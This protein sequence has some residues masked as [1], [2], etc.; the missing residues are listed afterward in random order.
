MSKSIAHSQGCQFCI[1]RIK[2]FP[3]TKE[4]MAKDLESDTGTALITLDLTLQK[5]R[6]KSCLACPGNHDLARIYIDNISLKSAK[7]WNRYIIDVKHPRDGFE[8]FIINWNHHCSYAEVKAML[9]KDDRRKG[10][11]Q[12]EY[13]PTSQAPM[14]KLDLMPPSMP[15]RQVSLAS[16]DQVLRPSACQVN[17]LSVEFCLLQWVLSHKTEDKRIWCWVMNSYWVFKRTYFWLFVAEEK[18]AKS[19]NTHINVFW[20]IFGRMDFT[21]CTYVRDGYFGQ[22][23]KGTS[24]ETIILT[25]WWFIPSPWISLTL[26]FVFCFC[27]EPN[28]A[29]GF[30]PTFSSWITYM[31]G[32]YWISSSRNINTHMSFLESIMHLEK[33]Y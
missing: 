33:R 11:Q 5:M 14:K 6:W 21:E 26:L 15:I 9:D 29:N 13:F 23:F 16:A 7:S 12:Y 32:G 30:T 28:A 31:W 25:F 3:C 1:D 10:Q 24:Q 22:F 8:E 20:F 18:S 2:L 27:F 19:W 4:L 17:L